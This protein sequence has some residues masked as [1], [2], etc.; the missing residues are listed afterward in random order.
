MRAARRFVCTA[1]IPLLGL[2]W[3]V[4]SQADAPRVVVSIKPV[5]ALVT[6]VMEGV[7]E[8]HLI[9]HGGASPHDY[10]LKPSDARA[11]QAS[12]IVF[13]V[14]PQ[15]ESALEKPLAALTRGRVVTL[16]EESG[17]D[18][19]PA[20]GRDS[21]RHVAL[22]DQGDGNDRSGFDGH[23][24]LDPRNAMRIVDTV[25]RVL[26]NADRSNAAKYEQNGKI[27]NTRLAMLDS[28]LAAT[29][30]PLRGTPYVVFHD[31]YR[32]FE[33][34]YGLSAV[35]VVALRPGQNPGARRVRELRRQLVQQQIRCL[36]TEP[37]FRAELANTLTAGT[38]VH[39]AE[40]DPLGAQLKSGRES[41]FALMRRLAAGLVACLSAP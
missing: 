16:L 21:R 20:H 38:D 31:A 35:G 4:A 25:V 28:E 1:A 10:A 26:I 33:R 14:G 30:T 36:F 2:T 39:V 8:P 40:L 5:H 23:I 12:R 24:W 37:Q 22:H 18:P 41:Y 13:W 11:L 29:L 15:V 9:V 19:L 17:I 32:Y 34:R 27:L 6:G 7:G 3:T